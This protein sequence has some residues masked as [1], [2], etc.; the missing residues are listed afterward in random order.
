MIS[1]EVG[2]GENVPG[3]PGANRNFTYL[4]RGPYHG[5]LETLRSVKYLFQKLY[6]MAQ[7]PSTDNLRNIF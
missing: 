1:F 3:I 5:A 2:G 7:I 6:I 4:A